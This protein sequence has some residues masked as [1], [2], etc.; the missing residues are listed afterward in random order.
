MDYNFLILM[1]IIP[2]GSGGIETETISDGGTAGAQPDT[3]RAA[4]QQS[5]ASS[6]EQRTQYVNKT[7][8]ILCFNR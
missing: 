5:S 6:E 7:S 8:K 4:G 2:L 1:C 3:S